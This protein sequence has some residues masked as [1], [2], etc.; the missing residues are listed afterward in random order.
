MF[1]WITG[2]IRRIKERQSA[3]AALKAKIAEKGP[4]RQRETKLSNEKTM[5]RREFLALGSKGALAAGMLSALTFTA[6]KAGQYMTDLSVLFGPRT[7]GQTANYNLYKQLVDQLL[8]HPLDQKKIESAVKQIDALTEDADSKSIRFILVLKLMRLSALNNF[9]FIPPN[10]ADRLLSLLLSGEIKIS[11]V[12]EYSSIGEA[13]ISAHY[14]CRTKTLHVP[15]AVL[16][17]PRA[18]I[19]HEMY[20]A[21][22]ILIQRDQAT[23]DAKNEIPAYLAQLDYVVS[24]SGGRIAT[25]QS[26][27]V[28][29]ALGNRKTIDFLRSYLPELL[30]GLRETDQSRQTARIQDLE[31]FYAAETLRSIL[32][33]QPFLRQTVKSY[34]ELL[35]ESWRKKPRG[36]DFEAHLGQS[37]FLLGTDPNFTLALPIVREDGSRHTFEISVPTNKLTELLKKLCLRNHYFNLGNLAK[38]RHFQRLAIEQLI[39]DLQLYF[40]PVT[41][42]LDSRPANYCL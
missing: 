13:D 36:T 16:A 37:R 1:T 14:N 40:Q 38:A 11:S 23:S 3:I 34:L 22:Q 29:N 4:K 31:R 32:E 18:V 6:Y 17:D 15:P 26:A 30:S 2:P 19:I 12:T 28:E 39:N 5:L 9:A 21:Y 27:E 8:A 35:Y 20:H 10:F 42:Y 41:N 25:I 33:S 7:F 24:E